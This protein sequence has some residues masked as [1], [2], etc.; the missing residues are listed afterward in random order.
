[1]E[2]KKST[3]VLN[4]SK[5]GTNKKGSNVGAVAGAA[6]VAGA[7]GVAAGFATETAMSANAEE[8]VNEE[9]VVAPQ[10]ATEP[11]AEPTTEPIVES[12]VLEPEPIA[13]ATEIVEENVEVEPVV[14]EPIS[15]T[16]E[17]VVVNQNQDVVAEQQP[18][19]E[20]PVLTDV[21]SPDDVAEAVLSGQE[22]DPNDIDAE[23]MILFDDVEMVYTVEGESY[24]AAAFH[25][26][27][28]NDMVMADLDGDMEFDVIL[29]PEGDAVAEISGINASDAE[30]MIEPEPTYMAQNEFDENIPMEGESFENDMMLS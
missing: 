16:E 17:P 12:E 11:V 27:D 23:E 2:S 30:M 24:A 21:P 1:M 9:V 3:E 29:T 22:I 4:S 26:T 10:P 7:V 5:A 13:V 18:N 6:G 20:T 8:L 25:D 14:P 28:G 15:S 19:I